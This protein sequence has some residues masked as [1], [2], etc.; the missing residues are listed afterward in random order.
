MFPKA[1]AAA[2]DM[3]A[4]R[5]GWYKIYYPLAFYAGMLTVAP[6][7]FDSEIALKGKEYLKG[8]I[9]EIN[10][11]GKEASAAEKD[12]IP[13]WQLVIEFYA[14]GLEFLPP[15]I[16][17]SKAK[18]FVPEDG[19]LRIPYS[20]LPGLGEKAAENLETYAVEGEI[21]SIEDLQK[22]AGLSKTHMEILKRN[23]VLNGLDETTQISF[24]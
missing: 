9:R 14:R 8:V 17:K 5:L 3:S 6:G 18:T 1:H 2:Y 20:A 16:Y 19:K 4:I 22:V 21:L 13:I 15:R 12:M 24:F 11:K 23:G 10:E 7:G